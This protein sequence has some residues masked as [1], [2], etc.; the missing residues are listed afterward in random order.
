MSPLLLLFTSIGVLTAQQCGCPEQFRFKRYEKTNFGCPLPIRESDCTPVNVNQPQSGC[1][2]LT[3]NDEPATI[4]VNA[5]RIGNVISW[6]M[7]QKNSDTRV[8]LAYSPASDSV[9]AYFI[10][11]VKMEN[12]ESA[13]EAFGY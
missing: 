8:T 4:L 11:W 1:L 7:Q 13:S 2:P 9:A 10:S 6:L 12:Y 5:E 3:F